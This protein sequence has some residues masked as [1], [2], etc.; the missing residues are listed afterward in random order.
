M[1]GTPTAAYIAIAVERDRLRAI[2]AELL[3][4]LRS[5]V[6][7]YYHAPSAK[8]V[9]VAAEKAKAVIAKAEKGA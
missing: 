4:A 9:L 2:N 3:E 5:L 8:D 1:S 6:N 7:A